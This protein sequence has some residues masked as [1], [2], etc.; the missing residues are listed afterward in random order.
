MHTYQGGN[1]EQKFPVAWR[2]LIQR[3][4][5]KLTKDYE[6]L[7]KSQSY[8]KDLNLANTTFLN[9]YRSEIVNS[10]LLRADLEELARKLGV[11]DEW[12]ELEGK[13]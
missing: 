13:Q 12:E 9:I 4:N 2:A 10:R 7:W 1:M 8:A 5:G 6:T 3:L 11:L